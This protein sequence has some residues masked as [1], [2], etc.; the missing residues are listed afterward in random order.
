MDINI[1][2]KVVFYFILH[3]WVAE[4]PNSRSTCQ[5][6]KKEKCVVVPTES[7]LID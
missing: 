5:H 6:Y 1:D 7:G 4:Y 3:T 2:V